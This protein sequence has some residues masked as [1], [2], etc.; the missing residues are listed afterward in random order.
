MNAPSRETRYIDIPEAAKSLGI[1]EHALERWIRQGSIP[2]QWINEKIVF[3]KSRLKEWADSHNMAWMEAPPPKAVSSP[4]TVSLSGAICRGGVYPGVSGAGVADVLKSAANAIQL[5]EEIDRQQLLKRLLERETLASTGIGS[6]AA[7]PHPRVPLKTAFP[8]PSIFVCFL[9]TEI[10][11]KAVDGAPVFVLFLMLSPST[12]THLQMLARLGYCLR[13]KSFIKF[14]RNT[15]DL[16]AL[17][18]RIEAMEDKMGLAK[19][20]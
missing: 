3:R 17:C 13:D 1:S 15:P 5:P 2:Y 20:F 14:L 11:Y 16:N 8:E 7:V 12:K 18:K 9:E 4:E 6:G 19:Q 10:D